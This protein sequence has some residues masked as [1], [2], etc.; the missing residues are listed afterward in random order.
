MPGGVEIKFLNA[1][2]KQVK[3]KSIILLKVFSWENSRALC[4]TYSVFS[5]ITL[6]SRENKI[7]LKYCTNVHAWL[8]FIDTV[9]NLKISTIFYWWVNNCLFCWNVSIFNC[10]VLGQ[11]QF[12]SR[13]QA[14]WKC[15]EAALLC[16]S[17]LQNSQYFSYLQI[18]Y[19]LSSL[20]GKRATLYLQLAIQT[21]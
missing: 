17:S 14:Q 6:V 11:N 13:I 8:L 9:H 2:W 3:S 21:K 12:Y 20:K 15:N 19:V 5:Y 7:A 1:F 10:D 16:F 4:A 18:L